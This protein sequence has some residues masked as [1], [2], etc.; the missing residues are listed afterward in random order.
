MLSKRRAEGKDG[1]GYL[2]KEKKKKKD[3]YL[4]RL[5]KPGGKFKGGQTGTF[6]YL[7]NAQQGKKKKKLW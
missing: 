2:G 6:F 7:K 5:L 3:G 4:L 1:T